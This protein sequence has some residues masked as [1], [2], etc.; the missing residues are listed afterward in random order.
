M[1]EDL[2]YEGG[3]DID[4]DNVKVTLDW[5][6][7]ELET[8]IKREASVVYKWIN[9]TITADEMRK[10]LGYDPFTDEDKEILDVIDENK[11]DEKLCNSLIVWYPKYYIQKSTNPFNFLTP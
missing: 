10:E 6:E 9:N 4:D 11:F 1:F 8:M 7:I 2:L 3:F 5:P